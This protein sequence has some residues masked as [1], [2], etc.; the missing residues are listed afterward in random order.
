MAAHKHGKRGRLTLNGTTYK[1]T[2]WDMDDNTE[3]VEVTNTESDGY[4]EMDDEGG[5]EKCSGSFTMIAEVGQA[6]PS[7][8]MGNLVLQEG[9][10]DED[11]SYAF[12]AFVGNWKQQNQVKSSDPITWQ[13][14]YESSGEIARQSS[15]VPDPYV[16]A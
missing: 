10:R 12:K 4:Q 11:D 3:N 2:V 9:G 7:K 6:R 8:G 14:S 5:I 13:A 16:P 15:T 1:I